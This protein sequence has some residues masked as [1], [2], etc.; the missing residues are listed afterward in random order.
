[1]KPKLDKKSGKMPKFCVASNLVF[2]TESWCT[3][4]EQQNSF[5]VC[6][7]K[8]HISMVQ[9]TYRFDT[10]VTCEPLCRRRFGRCR[11]GLRNMPCC[12]LSDLRAA[13]QTQVRTLQ[14]GL[15]NVPCYYLSDQ[16]AALQAQVRALQVGSQE[17]VG[18]GV[19]CSVLNGHV[20]GVEACFHAINFAFVIW[21]CDSSSINKEISRY[22]QQFKSRYN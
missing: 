15:R 13:L 6:Q 8:T 9:T 3:K 18:C 21:I 1:M 17:R 12:Y 11:L 5:D 19:S 2:T 7:L 20:R 10:L 14:V 22:L 16:W 4:V